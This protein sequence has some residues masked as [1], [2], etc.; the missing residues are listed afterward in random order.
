MCASDGCRG[1]RCDDDRHRV[2]P[3]RPLARWPTLANVAFSTKALACRVGADKAART[4]INQAIC[5]ACYAPS[6][7]DQRRL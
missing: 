1:A 7:V 4:E 2:R 5:L 6:G 3:A